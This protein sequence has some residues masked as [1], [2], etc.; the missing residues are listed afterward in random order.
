[1]FSKEYLQ[2]LSRQTGFLPEGLQK[3]MT[4]LDLLREIS[5]HPLLRSK[6]ALKGGTALNLFW[7]PLPRLSVDIDLNY[8]ATVDRETML[9]DRPVLEKELK[10]LIESRSISV[11]FAPADEHAGAK[12]RLRAPSA[13]GGN[14][15]LE[16]DLNYIMRIPIGD[17]RSKQPYPLDE[18]YTFAFDSV[19]FE[20]LF[21]GKIKALLERSAA[22]DLYDVAML[23]KTSVDY[24]LPALRKANILLG[25]TSK[26]DWRN[27]DLRTIDAIDQ[28]MIADE[29]TPILRQDETPKLDVMRSDAKKILDQILN[30]TEKEKEF[31][32]T[33][34]EM[35]QYKPELLFETGQAQRLM[36]HPA[37]LWKLHNL[38]KFKGL[39]KDGN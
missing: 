9:N 6:F 22:R 34:E 5:R 36:N 25:I 37:V 16:L 3:Q 14:F 19:S 2:K 15:A 4:L 1:V 12:W 28:K 11:Q 29:L 24:D 31:L 18:D 38:R 35:G 27:I 39:D 8:I 32:D 20:E 33:F 30:R 10:K 21:A 7:F 23:S 26:R 13:F 17:I